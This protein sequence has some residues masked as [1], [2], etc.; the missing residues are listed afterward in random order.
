MG[1]YGN[2]PVTGGLAIGSVVVGQA[3]LVAMALGLVLTGALLVRLSFRKNKAAT[4]R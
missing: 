1:N 2:L 3:S 4:E